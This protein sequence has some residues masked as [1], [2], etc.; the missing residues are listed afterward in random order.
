M[1]KRLAIN[2]AIKKIRTQFNV[3]VPEMRLCFSIVEQ[4][5]RDLAAEEH[6]HRESAAKYLHGGI[7]AAELCGVEPDWIKSVL[8][9]T[10]CLE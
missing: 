4:A 9:N 8:I 2:A 5:I 1:N 10:G 7:M 6:S 3:E